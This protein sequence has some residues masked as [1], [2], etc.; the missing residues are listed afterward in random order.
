MSF[1]NYEHFVNRWE[2]SRIQGCYGGSVPPPLI[3]EIFIFHWGFGPKQRLIPPYPHPTKNV[4]PPP[5]QILV[6]AHGWEYDKL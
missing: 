4:S 5:G 6:Y 3:S 1:Q 2:Q